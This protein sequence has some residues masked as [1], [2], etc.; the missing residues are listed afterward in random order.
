MSLAEGILSFLSQPLGVVQFVAAVAV[1]TGIVCEIVLASIMAWVEKKD[2]WPRAMP[3]QK[4]LM[5]SFGFPE[6]SCTEYQTRS[7]YAYV[8]T[9][10]THHVVCGSMMLPVVIFGWAGAQKLGQACFL[11]GALM[12]VSV[13]VYDEFR[14]FSVTFLYES[15]GQ[16]LFGGEKGPK[17][18]FVVV[19]V[20][21]HPLAMTMVCPLVLHYP[22]LASF[23][24]VALALL[25]AA[26]ICFTTGS[27]KFTLDVTKAFDWYQFKAIVVLQ[28]VTILYT[29]GYVW[30]RH[31]YIVLCTF[32]ADGSMKFFCGGCVA[33]TLMSLFNLVMIADAVGAAVKWLP[34]SM[35][36]E[37]SDEQ[38]EFNED[39]VMR[40]P[41]TPSKGAMNGSMKAFA[42]LGLSPA[43]T[44]RANVQVTVA[45]SKFK[46]GI[47]KKD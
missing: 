14:M 43:S 10:C 37:G 36:K 39:L 27:Y 4:A 41:S 29:R 44:F 7:G 26:G 1:V 25:F 47:Q 13:D 28:A 3:L 11:V 34:R 35:V 17:Q 15:V 22:D 5:M 16:K 6:A 46:K 9:L 33:G 19:G 8:I 45:A 12:D 31:L 38:S 18:F 20:L 42:A 30:F 32:W 2:W 23:H 21:H 24:I 40:I